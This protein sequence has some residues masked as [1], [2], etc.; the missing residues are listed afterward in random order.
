MASGESRLLYPLS[1][2]LS[3]MSHCLI[4][5]IILQGKI[6]YTPIKSVL[7]TNGWE[8]FEITGTSRPAYLPLAKPQPILVPPLRKLSLHVKTT[9]LILHF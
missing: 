8:T 7:D 4:V 6:C 1:Y 9:G 5:H 3:Q 2:P